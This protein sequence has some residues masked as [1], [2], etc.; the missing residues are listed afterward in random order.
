MGYALL[1][2]IWR[3]FIASISFREHSFFVFHPMVCP[4]VGEDA[5]RRDFL[6]QAMLRPNEVCSAVSSNEEIQTCHLDQGS[7]KDQVVNISGFIGLRSLSYIL[8]PPPQLIKNA[9]IILSSL[10]RLDLVHVPAPGPD[11]RYYIL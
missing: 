3:N 8:P 10:S 11:A 6:F 5:P 7:V 2:L 9:N 1:S 4:F